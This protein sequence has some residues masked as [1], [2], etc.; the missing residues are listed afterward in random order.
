MPKSGVIRFVTFA[1]PLEMEQT[2]YVL[3][4]SEPVLQF[5][6]EEKAFRP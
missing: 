3:P 5:R 4:G 6:V 2:V 1:P